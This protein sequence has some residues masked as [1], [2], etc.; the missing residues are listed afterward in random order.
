V[1]QAR[2]GDLGLPSEAL[3]HPEYPQDAMVWDEED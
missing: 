3:V 1:Y 2:Y